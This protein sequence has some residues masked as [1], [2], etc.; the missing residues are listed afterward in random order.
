MGKLMKKEIKDALLTGLYEAKRNA[1]KAMRDCKSGDNWL[2]ED[3][4][5]RFEYHKNVKLAMEIEIDALESFMA[6]K[7][8][9]KLLWEKINELNEIIVKQK[10]VIAERDENIADLEQKRKTL[11]KDV[12]QF[13]KSNQMYE[14]EN[15]KLR[16]QI[17]DDLE[18][19]RKGELQM[20]AG[21][22]RKMPVSLLGE[23]CRNGNRWCARCSQVILPRYF[24]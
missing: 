18:F 5:E 12:E 10:D 7:E 2:K 8:E 3:T 9:S 4:P 15:D 20:C 6:P 14:V 1:E 19:T 11:R 17:G 22:G 24:N 23:K 21:C 13:L 16:R